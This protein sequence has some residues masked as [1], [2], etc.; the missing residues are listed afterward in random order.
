MIK[1]SMSEV[2]CVKLAHL[3][4]PLS[5]KLHFVFPWWLISCCVHICIEMWDSSDDETYRW[6]LWLVL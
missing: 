3:F 2:G 1:E 6:W 4:M 5:S